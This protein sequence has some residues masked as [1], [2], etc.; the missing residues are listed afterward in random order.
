M[1]T[2]HTEYIIIHG[3]ARSGKTLNAEALKAH[4]KCDA[5]CDPMYIAEGE[6]VLVLSLTADIKGPAGNRKMF[7]NALKVPVAEAARQLGDAW[8]NPK[9]DFVLPRSPISMNQLRPNPKKAIAA[10]A[11]AAK[12]LTT[13]GMKVEVTL[14]DGTKLPTV[15]TSHPWELGHGAWVCK[16]AGKSGGYDCA[17]I[18]PII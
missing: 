13:I 15:T 7:K 17:R 10:S 8:V 5:V 3:P 4:F 9:P 6:R 12:L 18:K 16:I 11:A 14:D 1:P 2:K